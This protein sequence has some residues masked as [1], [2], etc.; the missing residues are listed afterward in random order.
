[1]SIKNV[2]INTI[3]NSI[4][5]AIGKNSSTTALSSAATFTGS[6]EQNSRP[7][8]MVSCQT[9]NDGTLYFDFR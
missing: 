5:S 6:W 7:D 4:Q 8:V 2:I 1:M 9:D 3:N